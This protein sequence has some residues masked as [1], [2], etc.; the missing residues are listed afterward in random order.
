M[1]NI[2]S[3][4]DVD[5]YFGLPFNQSSVDNKIDNIWQ[6][7]QTA[8]SILGDNLLGLQMGNEPDL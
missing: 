2:S 8:Q 6:I 3:I 4:V 1:A 7:A 5:W